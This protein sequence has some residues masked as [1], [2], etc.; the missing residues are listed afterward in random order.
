[1]ADPGC[2]FWG[3]GALV[4]LIFF[5]LARRRDRKIGIAAAEQFAEKCVRPL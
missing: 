1:V 5:R 4:R 3:P 2:A